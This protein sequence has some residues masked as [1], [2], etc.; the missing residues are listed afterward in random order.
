MTH[1]EMGYPPIAQAVQAHVRDEQHYFD[2]L[3]ARMNE[4][5]FLPRDP[6]R[7]EVAASASALNL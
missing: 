7:R 1:E 3:L 6:L 4:T 2:R 5:G